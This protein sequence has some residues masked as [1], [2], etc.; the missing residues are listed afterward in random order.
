MTRKDVFIVLGEDT[1]QRNAYDMHCEGLYLRPCK[2][3]TAKSMDH[4]VI[5]IPGCISPVYCTAPLI[6]TGNAYSAG[7][8][9]VPLI[10]FLGGP[11]LGFQES[12]RQAPFQGI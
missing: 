5:G 6:D 7:I 8:W 11:Q 4:D 12:S 2:F 1:F 10:S 9:R 3:C